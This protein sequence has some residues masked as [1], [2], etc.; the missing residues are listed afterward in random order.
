MSVGLG[1]ETGVTSLVPTTT[2]RIVSPGL[3]VFTGLE[4]RDMKFTTMVIS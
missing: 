4:P 1:I 3:S 2:S